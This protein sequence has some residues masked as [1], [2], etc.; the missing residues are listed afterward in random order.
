M[1]RENIP[2]H[3]S[4]RPNSL[5]NNIRR[6][7]PTNL[8][9][10]RRH[11]KLIEASR[12]PV[13]INLNPRSL[14][15]KLDEFRTLIEQTE[16]GVC[17]ISETWDRTHTTNGTSITDLLPIDNYCWIKNVVQRRRRG[18]KPA[19]LASTE[20]FH[21]TELSPD[22]I[23]V[24]IDVEVSW[25]LLTPKYR[26]SK[27]RFNHIAVASVYYS[28]SQTRKGMFLDHIV[29]S[30]NILSSKYGSELGFLM[31][32]DVNKL[33]LRPILNMSPDLKQ[34]VKVPTRNNPDAILDVIVTNMA[35]LYDD[36]YTLSPLDK[37]DDQS[38]E[39]SDHNIV[40]M[41][42]L[43]NS[44][45]PAPKQYKIIKYRPFPDSGLREFGRWIQAQ[46]WTEIYKTPSITEKAKLFEN[47]LMKKVESVFPG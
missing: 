40:I 39:A 35:A 22:I 28:S 47:I 36:P 18:G 29:E 1:Y 43:S 24:P 12:L 11:D 10:I 13:V 32:G 2:V 26:N 34:V 42:P 4:D 6:S 23:T 45:Q 17:C 37:D 20:H 15:N 38:G 9:R 7:D 8:I 14:Y 5:Q 19:I 44:S 30:Y 3:I 46:K 25:A 31:V 21:V 33:N 27:S 16:A 41:K